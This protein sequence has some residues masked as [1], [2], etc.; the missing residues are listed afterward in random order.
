MNSS[1]ENAHSGAIYA[2]WTQPNADGIISGGKDGLVKFWDLKMT[3]T[4]TINV[5]EQGVFHSMKPMVRAI[6]EDP[7]G[8]VQIGTRGGEIVEVDKQD[9][10]TII[11]QGHFDFELWG[12][13][14]H[15]SKPE[16]ATVG[17]DFLLAKWS[18]ANRKQISHV[19]LEFQG[20][21]IDYNNSGTKLAVGCKNGRVLIIDANTLKKESEITGR[22]KEISEIKFSPD[23]SKIAVG[24]H[25]SR[26]YLYDTITYKRL[27]ICKGHHSTITHIDWSVDSQCLESNCTSYE[28]L[29]WTAVNGKQNTSGASANRDEK[30]A[31]WTC[32]I[33]WPA[34][35][36]WPPCADGSDVNAVSRNKLGT[37]LA[38]A[39]DFGL[40]KLF[41]YPVAEKQAAFQKFIGH[42]SHVTNVRFQFDDKYVISTGGND[43]SIFQW[44]LVGEDGPEEEN[45]YDMEGFDESEFN[46]V[47]KDNDAYEEAGQKKAPVKQASTTIGNGL[48]DLEEVDEGDQFMAIKPFLGEVKHSE[49]TGFKPPPRCNEPPIENLEVHYIHGCRLFDARNTAK[50]TSDTNNCVFV[51]AA[52]GVCMDITANTQEFFK[53]H[54]ED[55]VSFDLHPNRKI[56]ASGSMPAKGRSRFV[57]IYVWDVETKEQK[58]HQT[59]FHRGSIKQL[60]FSPDGSKI[61]TFGQDDDNSMAIYE[62]ESSRL[63]CTSKVDRSSVLGCDWKSETELT[64]CGQAHQKVWTQQGANV[65]G[66]KGA[67]GRNKAEPLLEC[68]YVGNVCFTAGWKGCIYPWSGTSVGKGIPAHDAVYTLAKHPSNPNQ[69]YSGGKDGIIKC[70][71]VSGQNLTLVKAVCDMSKISAFTPGIRSMD[72]YPDGT[73]LVG[74]RG[75]EL[76]KVTADGHATN[77]LKGHC[78]G[79]L[80]GLGV[81][82]D[83]KFYATCGGDKSIRTWDILARKQVNH[84]IHE[85]DVRA[86][87][88]SNDNT[89]LCAGDMQGQIVL[90]DDQLKCLQ[91]LQSSFKRGDQWIED[92]KISPDNNYVAFGAHMGVS[93]LEIMCTNGGKKQTKYGLLNVGFT[94]ALTHLDWSTDSQNIVCNSQAYELKY[95]N[96]SSKG[97]ISSSSAKDIEW[98]TWTC[99]LGWT[100]QGIFPGADGSDVN[101]VCRAT[102]QKVMATG[103]DFQKVNL[104]KYPSVMEKSGHKPY[105]GHASHVCK[106]KFALNDNFQL[107]VGGNDKTNIIW[108]TDFGGDCKYSDE[109]NDGQGEEDDEFRDVAKPKKKGDKYGK[110]VTE[111]PN[112]LESLE[113]S[114]LGGEGGLFQEEIITGG[115]EFMA[116]KPWL[117]AIKQPSDFG[118]PQRNYDKAPE[119]TMT[120]DYCHGYRAKDSRMNVYYNT[121]GHIVTHAAAVGFTHDPST[122]SQVFHTQH[123]DDIMSIAQHPGRDLF[124]TGEIGPKPYVFIW[125]SANNNTTTLEIHSAVK[126]GVESQAFSPSG[127]MVAASCMD[128]NHT[129]C[130]FKTADGSQV[131]SEKGDT[132]T[133]IGMCWYSESNFVS[134][135]IKHY[136]TWTLSGALLKGARGNFGK[137]KNIIVSHYMMSNKTFL[138]G[139]SNG[140]LQLWSGGSCSR[141]E[142]HHTICLDAIAVKEGEWILTGGKDHQLCVVDPTSYKQLK[143]IDVY[144]LCPNTFNGNVRALALDPNSGKIAMGLFSSE[145]YELTPTNVKLGQFDVKP[146]L[147]GHYSHN[148]QWTNEVWGLDLFKKNKDRY[149]TCS[150][151][152]TLREWSISQKK[153]MRGLRLDIDANGMILPPDTATKDQQECAKLRCC[154][155]DQN[156]TCIAV[157]CKDGTLRFVDLKGWKQLK[158]LKF[159]KEWISDLKFSPNND[160]LAIGSHDDTIYTMTFPGLKLVG[161][162]KKH[163]SFITHL[164]FSVDGSFLHST[165]GAYELLFWDVRNKKQMTSGATA[166]KDEKWATW[167]TVLGWPVQ[168]I[169]RANWDGSDVNMVDRSNMVIFS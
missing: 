99:T 137:G 9:K 28:L 93:K 53:G 19:Q 143:K 1:V 2:I 165:C 24:A 166:L 156:D 168:G 132:A 26:I 126:K 33:G 136:K 100:V 101:T 59:G 164:D 124:A 118:K 32:T 122:N 43:K 91:V 3:T 63:V 85:N 38:T 158:L 10:H 115:D 151:D 149:V 123:T 12:L 102:N 60:K 47:K 29:Y 18:I 67:W 70:W 49:P 20:K 152:G 157:G 56:A 161:R 117:G 46:A 120:L 94:S 14:V 106:V 140:E 5:S 104:Y 45:D 147:K 79:E 89:F 82:N 71:T 125:D 160:I 110:G 154:A 25:D 139:A 34:Q 68:L 50:W 146:I 155:V 80:W 51:S 72:V 141:V 153:Q 92:I 17:E 116:I 163:S 81:S 83:E 36:I 129:I 150:D 121:N 55:L 133:I 62:W 30:W 159:A 135:G 78:D 162:M 144:T 86:V 6:A 54:D 52:L 73:N 13:A 41:K 130:V 114:Q 84:Y 16:F 103:D 15:P 35:G 7:N 88:W 90:L 107:S 138:H 134:Y 40:V 65:R 66:V 148:T 145:I 98:D 61:A 131:G 108:K 105:T 109:L 58:A 31:T 42:S 39:D 112:P 111:E 23:D 169:F 96:I 119:I 74:T 57:D 11:I 44:K 75:C 48:F 22:T 37:I 113:M 69:I 167:T 142:K 128:D 127:D 4:R 95:C 21:V 77:F 64:T 27:A 97:P 76:Y 87:D 8:N